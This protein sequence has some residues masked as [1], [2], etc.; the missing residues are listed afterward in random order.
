MGEYE[1]KTEECLNKAIDSEAN[2]DFGAANRNFKY[3]C[4]YEG[5]ALGL[6][7]AKDYASECGVPYP[8][9]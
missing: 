9:C 7:S 6:P 5:K 8:G 3:A 4:F 2:K 1:D